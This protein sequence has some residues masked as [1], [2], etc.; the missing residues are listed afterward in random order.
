MNT[1]HLKE[2]FELELGGSISGLKIGYHTY[3]TLNEDKSNVIFA[4]HALTANS[5]VS[6]WWSG[7]FGENRLFDPNKYF[8]ICANNLGS[9]Y[10]TT[11]ADDINPDNEKRYGLDFPRITIR[12]TAVLH[13]LLL[14]HLGIDKVKFLIGGSCGGNI[15]QEMAILNPDAFENMILLCCS[16]KESPWVIG[17]HESQRMAMN[18]DPTLH[19]NNSIAGSEGLR[20]ARAMALPYYR[21]FISFVERQSESDINKT[22]NFRAASYLKYQ[23]EKFVNRFNAHSYYTLLSTLDT[24]NVGRNRSSIKEALKEIK[25]R[26]LVIGFN[27][28]LLIPTGEQKFLAE[29]IPNAK[30]EEIETLFGHDAF[31]IETDLI[32]EKIKNHFDY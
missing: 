25:A 28:D 31:L 3:G 27:T 13:Q 20:A 29:N 17:I 14:D 9:C 8:I 1:Y 30:Y 5:D 22:S 12:D 21:S 16:A 6:D 32:L 24:H 2:K 11:C 18:V 19:Q 15:S 4:V 7:L 10:G 23:G 26:T